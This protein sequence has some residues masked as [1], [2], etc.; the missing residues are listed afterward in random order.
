MCNC[1]SICLISAIDTTQRYIGIIWSVINN[2]CQHNSFYIKKA[3][4]RKGTNEKDI[5]MDHEWKKVITPRRRKPDA[6]VFSGT[7][8]DG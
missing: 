4:I 5:S 7:A 2:A 3:C 6:G 8:T 1:L